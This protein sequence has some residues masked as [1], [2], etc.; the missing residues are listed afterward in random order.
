M[1][2]SA[3]THTS[4]LFTLPDLCVSSLRS[5][6]AIII[7]IVPILSDDPRRESYENTYIM[8]AFAL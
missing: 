3:K 7:C 6:H 5:G 8:R 1:Q 4:Q 2:V